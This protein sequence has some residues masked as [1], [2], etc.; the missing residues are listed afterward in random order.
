MVN[1]AA[2][3]ADYCLSANTDYTGVEMT[4]CSGQTRQTWNWDGKRM[5]LFEKDLC[6]SS[7]GTPLPEKGNAFKLDKTARV[8]LGP[9]TQGADHTV[10]LITTFESMDYTES[11]G[12][13]YKAPVAATM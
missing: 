6:L 8:T 7:T 13:P 12:I 3:T 2:E 5:K 1:R 9:C 10:Q 11:Q 4:R